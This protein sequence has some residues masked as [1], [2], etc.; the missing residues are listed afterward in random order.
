MP[1]PAVRGRASV[2]ANGA[3]LE[4]LV[5]VVVLGLFWVGVWV[6]VRV[7][8]DE[9]GPEFRMP[10]TPDTPSTG[11]WTTP[12]PALTGMSLLQSWI[13]SWLLLVL[14]MLSLL[15]PEV[16]L[17]AGSPAGSFEPFQLE[18]YMPDWSE[19]ELFEPAGSV[20]VELVVV[21]VGSV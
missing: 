8:E 1:G 21:V 20:D 19:P 15:K 6:Q 2:P 13:G 4:L 16:L 7:T 10:S 11:T 17:L 18:W 5:E 3:Q 12:R 14:M 9:T